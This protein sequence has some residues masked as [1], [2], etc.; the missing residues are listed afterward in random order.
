MKTHLCFFI[1]LFLSVSFLRMHAE[2]FNLQFHQISTQNGLSQNTVRTVLNDR[3]GFIWA[4][5]L[6]GIN[7][8][9]GYRISIHKPQ[10]GSDNTLPEHRIRTLLED[11]HGYIWVRSYKNDFTCYDPVSNSFVDYLPASLLTENPV[12][13]EFHEATNGDIWLWGD[14]FGCLQI[15]QKADGLSSV[16]YLMDYKRA[17]IFLEDAQSTIW[18]GTQNSLHRITEGTEEVFYRDQYAFIDVAETENHIYFAT[19]SGEIIAYNKNKKTFEPLTNEKESI[20]I[21]HM[22]SIG[23]QELLLSTTTGI[24]YYNLR[25]KQLHRPAWTKDPDLTGNIDY[26]KDRKGGLWLYNHSGVV[27]YYNPA[28]S[29]VKKMTLIPPEIMQ[30]VD[31]ERYNI[32]IDSEGIIWITTYGN[33]F[34]CYDSEKDILENFTHKA[35]R[36]SP[37]SNYL[38]SIT[39]D[40]YGNIWIGSEYAGLLKVTKSPGYIRVIRPEENTALGMN[41][42]VRTLYRDSEDNIWVGTKSGQLYLY[43]NNLTETQTIF[44]NLMP[45]TIAEDRHQNMWVGTKG[46]GIYVIDRAT[47][48][49]KQ[50][51]LTGNSESSVSNLSI[52]SLLKDAKGRMWVGT[53]GSGLNLAVETASGTTFKHFFN[54]PGNSRFIRYIYQ[55]SK[56]LI[57]VCSGDG[58]IRF[59]PDELIEDQE[60]YTLFRMD[61]NNENSLYGNDIKTV[62]EDSHQNIWVGTA[63]G[64]LSKYV[65]AT[66]EKE[67]HFVN[68]RKQDGLSGDFVCGIMEDQKQNLWISTESGITKFD[69]TSNSFITY[70]FSD[71]TYGNQFNENANLFTL[72]GIM[73]WGSLDG[74]LAFDPDRYIPDQ[75]MPP[76]LLTNFFIYDQPVEVGP[77]APLKQALCYAKEIT[78][79]YKQN[80]FTIEFASQDMTDLT[81]N[82]YMYRLGNYDK[83]W[84]A[85]S[86]SNAATYKNLAPGKYVFQVKGTNSDGIWNDESTAITIL[87]TPPFWRTWYAYL[88]YFLLFLSALYLAF[89]LVMQFN[90]LNNKIKV[91]KELTNHKLRFFTNISHEFRTPLTLIRGAVDNMNEMP[92]TSPDMKRQIT[93]LGRNSVILTRLIDQLLEFRKLQNNV[94]TL[95]L[96]ETDIISFAKEI[97]IGFQDFA[98]QKNITYRL[99]TDVTSYRMYIDRRKVDKILYNLLSNA[100]KFTPWDYRDEDRLRSC[101][102]NLL[103]LR[104]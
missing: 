3:K 2:E 91:E 12:Y 38:L 76:V 16:P 45:Y 19:E 50:Q 95:D 85:V 14:N 72:D 29:Q 44:D 74:I 9:D 40:N 81:K 13:R 48:R 92:D 78:L 51:F 86:Y 69:P 82:K 6:D 66:P 102:A 94:L 98:R 53:Y 10:P 42:N 68:Y 88:A 61:I 7:R 31:L 41:N 25:N 8:Y 89:R 36:N 30:T 35:D 71:K 79:N 54:T 96:E 80:T 101:P 47:R 24:Y 59:D 39:E 84:S 37:A 28:T 99:T 5:T 73:L 93:L 56:G 60:A 34:F 43:N 1:G 97:Y 26:L 46:K 4:G 27:W 23:H 49:I 20:R 15:S 17:V 77:D 22:A 18:L 104:V 70:H 55:D 64:G 62:F 83:Q 90:T 57:W 75:D 87:I 32:F 11:R 63:G 100:F 33:G 103:H 21:R 58:V 65:P 67:E 52:F